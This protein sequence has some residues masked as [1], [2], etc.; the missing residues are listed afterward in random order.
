MRKPKIDPEATLQQ[1]WE[2]TQARRQ[3]ALEEIAKT[4]EVVRGSTGDAQINK[5][6]RILKDC[7]AQLIRLAR[8][9]GIARKQAAD[10]DRDA[11]RLADFG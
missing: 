11:L 9:L 3:K 10:E 8:E 5:W 7:D 2:E 1:L 6:Y 4:S